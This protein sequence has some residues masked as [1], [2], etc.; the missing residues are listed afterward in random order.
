[1]DI[2]LTETHWKK[3]GL[4]L[5]SMKEQLTQTKTG[6]S[7]GLRVVEAI[8]KLLRSEILNAELVKKMDKA[9]EALSKSLKALK[10]A[11]KKL[12]TLRDNM[13]KAVVTYR[14]EHNALLNKINRGNLGGLPGGL[15]MLQKQAEKEFST[16]NQAF[17]E[18]AMKVSA[19]ALKIIAF[20]ESIKIDDVNIS[21][22]AK[23]KALLQ[24]RDAWEKD[25]KLQ[26]KQSLTEI[27]KN[28]DDTLGR[29]RNECML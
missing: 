17:I 3:Q 8:D 22:A 23:W 21:N 20:I 19:D 9:L 16:E 18:G 12:V 29:L 28:Q 1:M 6:I 15:K 4:P 25:V 13:V 14:S 5:R 26:L 7:E 10:A 24:Q 27:V 11:D 2:L